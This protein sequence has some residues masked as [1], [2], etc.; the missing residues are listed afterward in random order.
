MEGTPPV[1]VRCVGGSHD[2]ADMPMHPI[3]LVDGS[4][5]IVPSHEVYLAAIDAP[6]G[7]PV[8]GP[9]DNTWERYVMRPDGV[10]WLLHFDGRLDHAPP[11]RDPR[12]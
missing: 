6:E 8:S 1:Y 9:P 11:P 5:L 10:G 7:E 4:P 12:G 2:G 3:A